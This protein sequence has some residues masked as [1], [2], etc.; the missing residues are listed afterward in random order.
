MSIT[1]VII[2]L[3]VAVIVVMTCYTCIYLTKH[4]VNVQGGL[5]SQITQQAG[6]IGSKA[7]RTEMIP[8]GDMELYFRN[9]LYVSRG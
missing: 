6:E 1:A 3:A 8:V 5:Q 9:G 7:S 4:R 2:V